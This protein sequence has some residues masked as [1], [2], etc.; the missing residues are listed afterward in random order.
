MRPNSEDRESGRCREAGSV[1]TDAVDVAEEPGELDGEG[2]PEVGVD[3]SGTVCNGHGLRDEAGA[4][5]YLP[6]EGCGR[7]QE[8]VR[9]LVRVGPSDAG[10]DRGVA[11]ADGPCRP[12]DRRALGGYSGPLDSRSDDGFHGGTQQPVLGCEA[13]GLLIRRGKVHDYHTITIRCTTYH[14]VI[15]IDCK[16]RE[17]IF[18]C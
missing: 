4:S 1:G 17:T 7:S 5:R 2:N 9:E 11:R 13:S 12:D 6:M 16:Q 18:L 14:P 10:A 8:A 15:L 3:G